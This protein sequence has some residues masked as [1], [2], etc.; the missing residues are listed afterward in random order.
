MRTLTNPKAGRPPTPP[1]PVISGDDNK[2][3]WAKIKTPLKGD[4]EKSTSGD[5]KRDRDRN[6]DRVGRPRLYNKPSDDLKD[7][8]RPFINDD[9]SRPGRRNRD[10]DKPERTNSDRNIEIIMKQAQE[11]L[12]DG[13]ITKPEYHKMIQEIWLMNEDQKLRAAQR[14]EK[15]AGTTVWEK[16]IDLGGYSPVDGDMGHRGKDHPHGRNGPRWQSQWQHPPGAWAHPPGFAGHFNSDFRPMGPW[17]NPRQFGPLRPDF[18]QFHG[19][20]SGM[21]P[22]PRM[23]PSLL[24]SIG[25]N[26]P[27]MTSMMPNCP[28]G[29][30]GLSNPSLPPLNGPP[31]LM[32][33][34]PHQ[35]HSIMGRVPSP[36]RNN[37]P[38]SL[39]K[40]DLD[41]SQGF[42]DKEAKEQGAQSR[43]LA[44]PDSQLI[45]EINKD[46]MKSINI[47]GIPRE[48]RYY[49]QTGVV[50]MNWDE[51]REIGFQDGTR[52]ILV[53]EK[54]TIACDFND[55]YKEFV[56]EGDIHR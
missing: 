38:N 51:P 13:S 27:M 34:G 45:D 7:R 15:E 37:S 5:E 47:D 33:N 18:N 40:F 44:L 20:N 50:F 2:A 29:P 41:D 48:I 46:T 9:D 10:M 3:S 55:S 23:G 4:R 24:G 26:G 22:G 28:I 49:G 21:G 19:F 56:H 1:P 39:P 53:D 54:D 12:N 8:R 42:I 36:A 32:M 14:K 35:Q 17:Q 52:R 6:K 43:E 25:P 30:L 11:Q 31:S 16:G